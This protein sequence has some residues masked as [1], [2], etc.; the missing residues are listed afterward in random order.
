ML[1]AQLSFLDFQFAPAPVYQSIAVQFA[2]KTEWIYV[3]CIIQ[4]IADLKEKHC[5]KGSD[6]HEEYLY[7]LQHYLSQTNFLYCFFKKYPL[8][9]DL[10]YTKVQSASEYIN[11]LFAHLDHDKDMICRQLCDDRRFSKVINIST[12]LSD[13]HLHGR[14]VVKIELDNE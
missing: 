6:S 8:L 11:E 1:Y 12:N 2:E 9:I 14:T 7:F 4:E 5:L 3:R 10:L 13:E